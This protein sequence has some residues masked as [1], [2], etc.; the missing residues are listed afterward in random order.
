MDFHMQYLRPV[1]TARSSDDTPLGLERSTSQASASSSSGEGPTTT[2]TKRRVPPSPS[3]VLGGFTRFTKSLYSSSESLEDDFSRCSTLT[4]Q[5]SSSSKHCSL[6]SI[7]EVGV[8]DKDKVLDARQFQLFSRQSSSRS[9]R[10]QDS[11]SSNNSV[12]WLNCYAA[13]VLAPPHQSSFASPGKGGRQATSESGS[14]QSL[15]G[16]SSPA[17]SLSGFSTPSPPKKQKSREARR[18]SRKQLACQLDEL[19]CS[20]DDKI[21]TS[22]D[23]RKAGAKPVAETFSPRTSL[24]SSSRS[25]DEDSDEEFGIEIDEEKGLLRSMESLWSGRFDSGDDDDDD[26]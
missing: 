6:E 15:S 14:S 16:F 24:A 17:H 11:F 26:D 7:D 1:S 5:F 20:M 10:S 22:L 25:S 2:T 18:P 19:I 23:N 12:D 21:R 13:S 4:S 9:L 3:S 8:E